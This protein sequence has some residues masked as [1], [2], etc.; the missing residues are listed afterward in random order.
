[1]VLSLHVQICETIL[2][3]GM[4][5]HNKYTFSG[6]ELVWEIISETDP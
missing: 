5:L 4:A 1:M 2:R 6:C 3:S